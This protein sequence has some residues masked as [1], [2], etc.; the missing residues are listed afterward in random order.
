MLQIVL[1]KHATR[2]RTCVRAV[3]HVPLL[4]LG[5]ATRLPLGT[6]TRPLISLWL[7]ASCVLGHGDNERKFR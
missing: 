7:I 1:P 2:L 3:T 4:L 6:R 5:A